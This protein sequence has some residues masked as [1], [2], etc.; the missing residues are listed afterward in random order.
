MTVTLLRPYSSYA[1]GATI[2]LDSATEASL[3]GQGYASRVS[4]LASIPPG[5]LTQSD[6]GTIARMT[7]SNTGM[8]V[9][10]GDSLNS[11][12]FN[13]VGISSAS[14]TGGV[15]TMVFTAFS[16]PIGSQVIVHGYTD[17]RWNGL[18]TIT[19]YAAANQ[20]Q[21][22]IDSAADAVPT[23]DLH[24]PCGIAMAQ[25]RTDSQWIWAQ[26]LAGKIYPLR[27]FAARGARKLAEI[28][29]DYSA[30][31][32]PYLTLGDTYYIQAGTN[33]AR[34]SGFVL[35]NSVA[36]LESILKQVNFAGARAIIGTIPPQA[37]AENTT[38]R[39]NATAAL[40]KEYRRLAIAYGARILPVDEIM[41]DPA[42]TTWGAISGYIDTGDSIHPTPAAMKAIG[43][44]LYPMLDDSGMGSKMPIP[45]TVSD[46]TA[47]F[48]SASNIL[49]TG[50]FAGTG[51]A[52][53]GAGVSGS[54]ATGWTVT[55]SPTGG[56][57]TMVASKGTLGGVGASQIITVD[58]TAG[59]C[60]VAPATVHASMVAGGTYVMVGKV[61]NDLSA[62]VRCTLGTIM[63]QSGVAS[64]EQ[65]AI[66][67]PSTTLRLP[68]NCGTFSF[69]SAPFVA[70]PVPTSCV[71]QAVF[72]LT[73]A[74]T[75]TIEYAQFAY[76]RID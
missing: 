61:K 44:V 38:A 36:A 5:G 16:P 73:G 8:L 34:D 50:F 54:V 53:S 17:A 57:A 67:A 27:V 37:G 7:Q 51:G 4:T 43:A 30:N 66:G 13:E 18:K 71:P 69:V 15:A 3:V 23:Q 25:Q 22:A 2:T 55:G 33:D 52:V 1:S 11:H 74:T 6:A 64:L 40:N 42:S 10:D 26:M 75:G 47:V 58:A 41:A 70:S 68:A 12:A 60:T 24:S 14:Q 39:V 72:V 59:V 29:R 49:A 46:S 32:A 45:A 19:G 62:D 28:A 21:F 48:A 35:A 20:I 56:A 63:T 9:L 65:R 76:R 31:V